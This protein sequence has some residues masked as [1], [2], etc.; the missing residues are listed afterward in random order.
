MPEPAFAQLTRLE[1]YC[2]FFLDIFLYSMQN[3]DSMEILQATDSLQHILNDIVAH[4]TQM[5]E[6][7]RLINIALDKSRIWPWQ[8]KQLRIF[9]PE[10]RN[11]PFECW[12]SAIVYA[13]AK[14]N[15]ELLG[16]TQHGS[17][18]DDSNISP[19]ILLCRLHALEMSRHDD[20]WE[21]PSLSSK[22]RELFW[23]AI[24][25]RFE[26]DEAGDLPLGCPLTGSIRLDLGY[27]HGVPKFKRHAFP[28]WIFCKV[29]QCTLSS[30]MGR[31]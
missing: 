19:G 11:I 13:V 23:A 9:Q 29:V 24:A 16:L 6:P 20:L 28:R 17:G 3:P 27:I 7:W 26:A 2:K 5:S 22:V 18:A 21:Y 25:L 30:E 4:I 31:L 1:L 10:L 8:K 14:A 12:K 15:M